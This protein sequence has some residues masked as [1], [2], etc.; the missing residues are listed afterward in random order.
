MDQSVKPLE[1]RELRVGYKKRIILGPLNLSLNS[2]ELLV[3][4]G[5]NGIGKTTLLKTLAGLLSPVAGEVL[6]EE[7]PLFQFTSFARS[8]K[9]AFLSQN[10]PLSWPFTVEELVAQGRFPYRRWF[11]V[12]SQADKEAVE[13]ALNRACLRELRHRLATELSP[14]G[15]RS[16]Y[17]TNRFPN[18][19]PNSKLRRWI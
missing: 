13:E 18:W 14:K 11:G 3:L 12:E 5:P 16:F 8:K 6:L 2:G 19:T 15:P 1:T 17:S 9:V 4:I 10:S 7:T